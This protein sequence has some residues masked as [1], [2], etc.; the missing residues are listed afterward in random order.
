MRRKNATIRRNRNTSGQVIQK[1]I[2]GGQTGVD[3]AALVAAQAAGIEIAGWIP[4]G[5][6]AEDGVIPRD[7]PNLRESASTN[8]AERT[9]LNVAEADATLVMCDKKPPSGGTA[10]T[11][12]CARELDKPLLVERLGS[13]D[14]RVVLDRV[15]QWLH[16][17]Q[18]GTLNVAGPRATEWSQGYELARALLERLFTLGT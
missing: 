7:F 13:T 14:Q 12:R 1:V 18:V 17:N 5:R 9:R 8:Y 16:S 15:S 2:S 4:R 3:R 11:I 10:W 6:R